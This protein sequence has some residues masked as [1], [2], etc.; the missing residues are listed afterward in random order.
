[1]IRYLH[2]IITGNSSN[3]MIGENTRESLRLYK[4][5]G[6]PMISLKEKEYFPGVMGNATYLRIAEIPK[7]EWLKV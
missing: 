7:Y 1:M 6:F 3:I 2:E 5:M 4:I